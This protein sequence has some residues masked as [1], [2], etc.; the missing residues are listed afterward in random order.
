MDPAKPLSPSAG[1]NTSSPPS[2][3]LINLDKELTCSICA[4][5]LYQPLAL[6]DCLHAFCGSCL[7]EWFAFQ[8]A[9][10]DQEHA[11]S[12]SSRPKPYSFTCPSC[13]ANV[14]DTRPNATV[15]TLLEMFLKEHPES[16]KSQADRDAIARTYKPGEPVLP[17][18]PDVAAS[19]RH[20][21]RTG[22]LRVD[23][24][25]E[26]DDEADRRLMEE[27]R[28]LSLQ[29]I[30]VPHSSNDATQRRRREPARQPQTSTRAQTPQQEQRRANIH[31]HVS[32]RLSHQSSL[33]SLISSGDANSQGMEE[34]ITRLLIEEGLLDGIDMENL[35]PEQEEE[36][37]DMI[38]HAY[39][40]RLRQRSRE[41]RDRSR[42]STER[43]RSG[44]TPERPPSHNAAASHGGGEVASNQSRASVISTTSTGSSL[45]P[46]EANSNSRPPPSTY[47]NRHSARSGVGDARSRSAARS[48][49][50]LGERPR[51]REA[52][53]RGPRH[54]EYEHRRS[55]DP[56][57]LSVTQEW[58]R[59]GNTATP[60]PRSG[61]DRP[62]Q[63][64]VDQQTSAHQS[65]PAR[66]ATPINPVP[67]PP[68]PFV[69]CDRCGATHIEHQVH[70]CCEKCAPHESGGTYDLCSRCYRQGQ[71][72]LHWYG[73]GKAAWTNFRRSAPSARNTDHL[74]PP[75][76]LRGQR[77]V[78][79]EHPGAGPQ[80]ERGVFC[81]ICDSNA[82]SCYWHCG[83]CNE[84]E[85]GF[86]HNC[87][88]S[89]HHCSHPLQSFQVYEYAT[90]RSRG[91]HTG[92]DRDSTAAATELAWIPIHP[93]TTCN[94]CRL[95]V[96]DY[97]VRLHCPEC[98]GGDY[99]LCQSCYQNLQAEGRIAPQDGLEGSRRC[100]TGH[101]MLL[102]GFENMENR[103]HRI[104]LGGPVGGW[105]M[106][107]TVED[108]N[109]SHVWHWSDESSM[110]Q[111]KIPSKA[112]TASSEQQQH[113][114][115]TTNAQQQAAA[116]AST[117]AAVCALW[118][119]FP[120]DDVKMALSFPKHA[121]IEEVTD[122]NGDWWQ[123]VY[124]RRFGCFP[125]AYTRRLEDLQ[126]PP[127]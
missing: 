45:Q 64:Q 7:K 109:K 120:G 70:Y 51:S 13:R 52:Q 115:N 36:I 67:A 54:M 16:A 11:R 28:D 97:H 75:H 76:I 37:S 46:P 20:R 10:A 83:Y 31:R 71:G 48:S 104:V 103:R 34:E 2:G 82:N 68:Q 5:I 99:D 106:D 18:Q 69:S 24:G 114:Q 105:S 95:P 6:L 108:P 65:P 117:N 21:S 84:G 85:W 89:G 119:F 35:Q 88:N 55:T 113:Q 14:R 47:A 98:E 38:A 61:E 110:Q 53:Q 8:K 30:S 102:I 29:E 125:A 39:R 90:G 4:D 122:I 111:R 58:R 118:Q 17:A 9:R 26:D 27:V 23:D 43:P 86:C 121:V 74:E 12:H 19:R 101:R 73:F 93:P 123:G 100:P 44:R 1:A 40:R 107:E 50:D 63:Y 15:T 126:V 127:S 92:G 49:T 41:P 42:H 59:G 25:S 80:L 94:S 3:G 96:A 91:G 87:V 33:R 112:T 32:T 57:N 72:C 81:D 77:Y 56:E 60:I 124:C 22:Q 79:S 62:N 66:V 78:A 116:P